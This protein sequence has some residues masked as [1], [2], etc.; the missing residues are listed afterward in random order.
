MLTLKPD[1][2]FPLAAFVFLSLS[3][4]ARSSGSNFSFTHVSIV[5]VV[6]G[7]VLTDMTVAVS[8][9]RIVSITRAGAPVGNAV[10]GSGKFLIPGLWDMHVHW[11]DEEY[12]TTFTVNGVTGIRLMNGVPG[13]LDW[14][15]HIESGSEIGPRMR[16]AGPFVDGARPNHPGLSIA[17]ATA[18]DA[19]AA[20]QMTKSMGFD[21]VKTYS[22][23]SRDAFFALADECKRQSF[24]FAGHVPDSIGA[25]EFAQQG[26]VSLEHLRRIDFACTDLAVDPNNPPDLPAVD[27]AYDPAKAATV[28]ALFKEMGT[29]QC[30]TLVV[31]YV[32][33]AGNPGLL[34][35]SH[36]H[37]LPPSLQA[38]YRSLM[39]SPRR[40]PD[41]AAVMLGLER[42]LVAA[43][44]AAGV[45]LLA[46][47]DAPTYGV[48]PGYGLHEE[49]ALLVAAGLSPL[50]AL[51]AATVN[52]ARFV[53]MEDQLGSVQTGKLADLV[54]LDGNPLTDIHNTTRI[55]AV[56]Q[57][58][59]LLSRTDLDGMLDDLKT[60]AASGQDSHPWTAN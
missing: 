37:Y 51:Q 31:S 23:L 47:T 40:P 48:F 58:G 20:V 39:L 50:Q 36:M 2:R 15:R 12:L 14:R 24:P 1:A 59:K 35:D 57:N 33:L 41:A 56:V 13:H 3:G 60:K 42:T 43:M 5:D 4:C 25:D 38:Y 44:Q 18:D 19:R 10:D 26:G 8:G 30:P 53:G 9:N 21:F 32:Q 28:L 52:P 54:L 22:G 11:A 27:S 6:G 46:G 7:A 55:Q 34:S 29:W 16:I 49:L 45:G 17:A